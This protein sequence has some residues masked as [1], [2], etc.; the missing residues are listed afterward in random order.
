MNIQEAAKEAM[1]SDGFI[2][3]PHWKGEVRLKPTNDPQGCTLYEKGKALC[4]RWQPHAEDLVAN[5]WE[6][7]TKELT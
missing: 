3:R 2:V 7:T 1:E 4:L 6:V 5:D